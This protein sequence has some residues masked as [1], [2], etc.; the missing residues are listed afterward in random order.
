MGELNC[1]LEAVA[2]MAISSK[3]GSTYLKNSFILSS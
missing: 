2:T 1:R 3:Y